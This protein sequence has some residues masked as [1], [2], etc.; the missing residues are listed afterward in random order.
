[1]LNRALHSIVHDFY[2]DVGANEPDAESVTK[3][4]YLQ[5]W[6]GINIE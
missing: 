2:V 1:M 3:L 6:H 4:F 5:G